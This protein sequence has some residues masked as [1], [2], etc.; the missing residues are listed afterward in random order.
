MSKNRSPFENY[1]LLVQSYEQTN[2]IRLFSL[3]SFIRQIQPFC[4]TSRIKN[5]LSFSV[6][7]S[8]INLLLEVKEDCFVITRSYEFFEFIFYCDTSKITVKSLLR[9]L[10][11]HNLITPL[12]KQF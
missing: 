10:F 3:D 7:G 12:C 8:N 6:R 11:H 1:T 9:K 2:P 5:S 4:K